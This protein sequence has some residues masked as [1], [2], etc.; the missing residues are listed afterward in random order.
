[1]NERRL[2]TKRSLRSGLVF[3]YGWLQAGAGDKRT[4]DEL[5][6]RAARWAPYEID[7][8]RRKTLAMESNE[9]PSLSSRTRIGN[10]FQTSKLP[11]SPRAT[12]NTNISQELLGPEPAEHGWRLPRSP[13]SL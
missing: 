8:D 6:E 2:P 13:S 12:A 3:S 9:R 7:Q 4:L 10:G 1:M 5:I 11:S